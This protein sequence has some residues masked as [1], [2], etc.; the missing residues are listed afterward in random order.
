MSAFLF[1][2]GSAV[3]GAAVTPPA[4]SP[5]VLGGGGKVRREWIDLYT[6]KPKRR[7]PLVRVTITVPLPVVELSI[8]GTIV[9]PRPVTGRLAIPV[10][11][12]ALSLSGTIESRADV[13]ADDVEDLELALAI[14]DWD[15]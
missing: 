15:D 7:I 13:L 4:T 8:T 9:N 1:L 2:T 6:K 3:A 5:E 12:F 10:P 11:R 14:A